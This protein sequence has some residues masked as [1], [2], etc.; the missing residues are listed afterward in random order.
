LIFYQKA[1]Q[2]VVTSH[3][4]ELGSSETSIKD[5]WRFPRIRRAAIII[6]F[7]FF[8]IAMVY[9]GINYNAAELPGS[10]WMNNGINGLLDA[11][12]QLLGT[13]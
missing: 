2:K 9:M 6:F 5:M 11:A 7:S 8:V 13:Y 4:F 1:P 3:Y 10:L 12:A